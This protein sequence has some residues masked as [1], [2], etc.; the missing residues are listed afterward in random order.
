MARRRPT[1]A[2]P[3][4]P[5][6]PTRTGRAHGPD[7]WTEW[8]GYRL[9]GT[10][11]YGLLAM[12]SFLTVIDPATGWGRRIG[13]VAVAAGLAG[14]YRSGLHQARTWAG[15][16]AGIFRYYGGFL[17]GFFTLVML[18]PAG[19]LLAFAAYW[20]L[21]AL[22][23]LRWSVPGSALLSIVIWAA[24]DWTEGRL[25]RPTPEAIGIFVVSVAVGG[26][27][28]A[29]IDAIISQSDDRK[30]LIG[31]LE[32]TRQELASAERRTGALAERQR[33]A[34][35][36]HDTLAQGFTSIVINLEAA[37]AALEDERGIASRHLQ[38]A[39]TTARESLTE[40]R[41]FVWA[42]RPEALTRSTLPEAL[43]RLT[44]RWGEEQAADVGLTV[45]GEMRPLRPEVEVT[46]L[47]VPQEAMTNA[48]KHAAC[49]RIVVS[50]SY[51]DDAVTLDVRD[52][53]RG[54]SPAA[55]AGSGTAG[56]GGT[57]AGFG[58]AAMQRRVEGVGG[59]LAVESA[60]GEGTAVA[61]AVPAG[62]ADWADEA[63]GGTEGAPDD[64]GGTSDAA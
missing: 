52:D 50:L 33:L 53:G 22:L 16:S 62:D 29:Y 38:R 35:E 58:L 48:S 46:L 34:G 14:W 26:L 57:G 60:P 43:A 30:R 7:V 15:P 12:A 45:T 18:H 8:R 54:F 6:A 61:V 2:L 24:G 25:T 49:Q 64:A 28:A 31:E 19:F 42:L 63:P 1:E 55:E 17:V 10:L 39:R 9:W 44:E 51:L 13:F 21:Y 3:A 47:R 20:Q 41:R 40:A 5:A 56:D 23:P 11:L 32:A 36:I 27:L 37:E 59:S 4:A